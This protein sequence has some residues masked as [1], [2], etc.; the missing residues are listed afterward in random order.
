MNKI[1]LKTHRKIVD[2]HAG[3][4]VGPGSVGFRMPEPLTLLVAGFVRKTWTKINYLESHWT[5]KMHFQNL[6][7]GVESEDELWTGCVG[8]PSGG[9]VRPTLPPIPGPPAE[10]F[11]N[12]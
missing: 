4:V 12:W 8:Y 10:Q 9:R 2:V 5:R 11:W 7:S 6:T 3:C 1:S